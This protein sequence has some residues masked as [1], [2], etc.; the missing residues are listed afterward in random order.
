MAKHKRDIEDIFLNVLKFIFKIVW[1]IFLMLAWACLRFAELL[2]GNI[3]GWI[4]KLIS[5]KS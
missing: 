3:A 2:L 5:N 1:K 4:K